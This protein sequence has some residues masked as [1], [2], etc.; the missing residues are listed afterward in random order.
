VGPDGRTYLFASWSDAGA[1][2]HTIVTPPSPA[3]Y[4]ATFDLAPTLGPLEFFT[5]PPCRLLDTRT[6]AAYAAGS[7]QTVSALGGGCGVPATA[8]AL[9]LNVTAVGSTTSGHLRLQAA[10]LPLPNTSTVNFA[11]GQ[12]RANN[13]VVRLDSSASF[14]VYV[15]MATGS[16]HVVVDVVGYFQ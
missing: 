3:T 14:I 10:D 9:A 1:A 2:S 13:A 16:V 7:T 11:A 8:R 4:T 5:V 12:T 6:S 15:G